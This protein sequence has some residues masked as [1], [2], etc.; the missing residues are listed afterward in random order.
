M[1]LKHKIKIVIEIAEKFARSVLLFGLVFLQLLGWL[2][3][4]NF[5]QSGVFNMRFNVYHNGKRT[6]ARV[7]DD[8]WE[9]FIDAHDSDT[10]E[11]LIQVS[12]YVGR[13]YGMHLKESPAELLKRYFMRTIRDS[14]LP[15]IAACRDPKQD[16][17]GVRNARQ[18]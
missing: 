1:L 3:L 8:L 12:Q 17:S 4:K 5:L 10:Q 7:P 2:L 11:A 13:W 6:T 16:K 18:D 14:M 15:P 9:L